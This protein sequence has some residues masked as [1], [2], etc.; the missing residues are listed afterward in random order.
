MI[1]YF[2]IIVVLCIFIYLSLICLIKQRFNGVNK[3]YIS[4]KPET[5]KS[6]IYG[7]SAPKNKLTPIFNVLLK[8]WSKLTSKL[9]INWTLAYG[10]LLGHQRNKDYI[11]YDSD[12]DVLVD[13]SAIPKLLGLLDGYSC[14]YQTDT[15]KFNK[16]DP[17]KIY[18]MIN[19]W[20]NYPLKNRRFRI[21]CLGRR[22]DSQVDDCSF[23]G[24]FARLIYKHTHLDIDLY[25]RYQNRYRDLGYRDGNYFSWF[26]SYLAEPLPTTTRSSLHGIPV[27]VLKRPHF[28]L[29]NYYGK[30]YLK[31][32]KIWKNKKWVENN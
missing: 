23:V 22:V 2:I 24:P 29:T 9:N 5:F 30:K 11:P 16:L 1:L 6:N 14:F 15:I 25:C 12:I 8:H 20:H 26:P 31:P 13:R 28:F 7:S 18:L 32:N 17:G 27:R 10:S 19:K 21:N 3:P 4:D